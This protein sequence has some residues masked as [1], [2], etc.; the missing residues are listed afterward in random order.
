MSVVTRVFETAVRAGLSLNHIPGYREIYQSIFGRD[1]EKQGLTD[2]AEVPLVSEPPEEAEEA[3]VAEAPEQEII[4][5]SKPG[6]NDDAYT[7][8]LQEAAKG[9][10]EELAEEE[11]EKKGNSVYAM[12]EVMTVPQKVRMALTGSATARAIL[13]KDGKQI[14]SLSVLNNPQISEK[15]IAAFAKNKAI[16]EG[17]IQSICRNREWT[18]SP[19]IQMSL[20]QHPKTPAAAVNRW[21]R[22]LHKNQLKMLAK[23]RDVSGH[24]NRMAKNVLQSRGLT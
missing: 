7:Q 5:E 8:A 13:I 21:I 15:E 16:P 19:M 3:E 18:K 9:D 4:E 6:L 2:E 22:S 11:Q 12:I 17:V 20:I 23:S 10:N 24:V 14:V 1:A